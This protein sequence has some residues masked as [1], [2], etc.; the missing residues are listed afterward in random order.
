M[1]RSS[2][3]TI[4][5][6]NNLFINPIQKNYSNIYNRAHT[7][8]TQHLFHVY[9]IHNGKKFIRKKISPLMIG[10]KFGEFAVTRKIVTNRILARKRK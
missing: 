1:A 8:T 5:H 10:H 4:F 9:F 2:Y 7:I 6:P 3:K